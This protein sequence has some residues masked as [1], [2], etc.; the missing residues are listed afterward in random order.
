MFDP[1]D[2]DFTY[3]EDLGPTSS[4][5]E[6]AWYNA[7]DSYV[8]VSLPGGRV[9]KYSN[10]DSVFANG[11]HNVWSVGSV[12][13]PALKKNYGPGEYLGDL[14]DLSYGKVPEKVAAFSDDF[15]RAG[16]LGASWIPTTGTPLPTTGALSG[17]SSAYVG[18]SLGDLTVVNEATADVPPLEQ[19]VN[20]VPLKIAD[21]PTVKTYEVGFTLGGG[22]VRTIKQIGSDLGA[23]TNAVHALLVDALDLES[24]VG[25]VEI[26][27]VT[28][29]G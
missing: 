12:W 22:D 25:E 29:V 1:F 9:Y 11:I 13:L 8:V 24:L 14:H 3:T 7:D 19:K 20:L 23:A 2:Y 15:S 6:R 4:A 17:S 28:R 21:E 16:S 27:S 10:V 5:V 18:L 26:V